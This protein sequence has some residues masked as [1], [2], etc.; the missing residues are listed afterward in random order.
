MGIFDTITR[1]ITAPASFLA[2]NNAMGGIRQQL[3]S[4]EGK[5]LFDS[6]KLAVHFTLYV[7]IKKRL[8]K[9]RVKKKGNNIV[10]TYV[11]ENIYNKYKDNPKKMNKVLLKEILIFSNYY[12]QFLKLVSYIKIEEADLVMQETSAII[13]DEKM[14]IS[15]IDSIPNTRDTILMSDEFSKFKK[16]VKRLAKKEAKD[17]KKELRWRQGLAIGGNKA[18]K[19]MKRAGGFFGRMMGV[20][21]ITHKIFKLSKKIFTRDYRNFNV[22]FTELRQEIGSRKVTPITISRIR[23][24]MKNYEK[25]RKYYFDID[26]DIVLLL[27]MLFEDFNIIINDCVIPFYGEVRHINGADI[28]LTETN[29]LKEMYK[30]MTK[31]LQTEELEIMKVN[32]QMNKLVRSCNNALSNVQ[33][34]NNQVI[35]TLRQQMAIGPQT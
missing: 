29:K 33:T 13:K 30:E 3:R 14:M 8:L 26:R 27:G 23:Y 32:Q 11:Q 22:E 2:S 25:I 7:K 28:I 4:Y 10:S 21:H 15:L 31:E 17:D 16:E 1:P 24:L 6:K 5:E 19:A 12:E 20:N 34:R 35:N 18:K 9:Y